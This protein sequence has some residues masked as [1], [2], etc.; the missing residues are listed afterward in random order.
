MGLIDRSFDFEVGQIVAAQVHQGAAALQMVEERFSPDAADE[1]GNASLP[2]VAIAAWATTHGLA[3][4][5]LD[6][7]LDEEV[8]SL[9]VEEIARQ[10][11]QVL[12]RGLGSF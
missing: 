6:G 2:G 4:L 1:S 7:M 11:T 8:D 12:G 10:V 5:L 3:F 9:G